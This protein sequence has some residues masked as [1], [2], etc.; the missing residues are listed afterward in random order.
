M[1]VTG[2]EWDAQWVQ[3]MIVQTTLETAG[4]LDQCQWDERS[5]FKNMGTA[6]YSPGYTPDSIGTRYIQ[7]ILSMHSK[8]AQHR[9]HIK[10]GSGRQN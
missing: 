1:G 10:E 8:F 9:C 4:L 6:V 7:K 5:H 2:Y 3:R